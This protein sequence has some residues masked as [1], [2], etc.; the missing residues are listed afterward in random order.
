MVQGFKKGCLILKKIIKKSFVCEN[1]GFLEGKSNLIFR[2]NIK[3]CSRDPN[4]GQLQ[5]DKFLFFHLNYKL[6]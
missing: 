1:K 2:C 4:L 3:I 5:L 6:G